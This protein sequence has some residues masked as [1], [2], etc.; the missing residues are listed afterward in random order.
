MYRH[1]LPS[2]P[3]HLKST[4]PTTFRLFVKLKL[5]QTF[6]LFCINMIT[7]TNKDEELPSGSTS[8]ANLSASEVARSVL[9]AVTARMILLG[10]EMYCRHMSLICTSM[11][12]GWSPTG[13]F[14]KPGKSTRVR[15]STRGEKTFRWIASEQIPCRER[16]QHAHI[17]GLDIGACP[18]APGK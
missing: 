2:Y 5:K 12:S 16:K 4:I 7:S 11:S 3:T 9:A 1:N 18:I 10:L 8:L 14:V 13:T 15:L 17:A 6:F